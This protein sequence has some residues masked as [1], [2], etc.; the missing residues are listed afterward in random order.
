MLLGERSSL[1]DKVEDHGGMA[2]AEVKENAHS[3]LSG[4]LEI[5][6]FS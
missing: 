3:L 1:R 5:L 4:R 6:V 2:L